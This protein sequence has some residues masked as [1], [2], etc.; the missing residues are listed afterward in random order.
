MVTLLTLVIRNLLRLINAEELL[1]I[2]LTDISKSK[3]FMLILF[4]G[5]EL[6]LSC[7]F[8]NIF[9]DE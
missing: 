8:I 3:S 7:I 5:P 6:T 1:I 9:K 4:N 2:T